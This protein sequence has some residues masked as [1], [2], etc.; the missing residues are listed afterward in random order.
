MVMQ[1]CI[2]LFAPMI[3]KRRI[4]HTLFVL[5][6]IAFFEPHSSVLIKLNLTRTLGQLRTKARGLL[7]RYELG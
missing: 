5:I 3:T 2:L 1:S 4:A 7:E 6:C